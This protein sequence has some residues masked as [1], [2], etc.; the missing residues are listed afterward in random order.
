VLS[1]NIFPSLAVT[2]F[3]Q[4]IAVVAGAAHVVNVNLFIAAETLLIHGW[5]WDQSKRKGN[6]ILIEN[7]DDNT[8]QEH[9]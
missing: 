4:N 3:V 7:K 6:Y 5:H 1:A 8:D 2:R 9:L